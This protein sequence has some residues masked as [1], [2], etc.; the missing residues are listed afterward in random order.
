MRSIAWSSVVC[1]PDLGRRSA[2]RDTEREGRNHRA[3]GPGV[4]RRFRSGNALDRALAELVLVLRPPL[5]FV[6]AHDR[7]DRRAFRRQDADEG[8]D[9]AGAGDRGPAFAEV[10]PRSEEHTSELQSL[11]R[12]SYA[13]SCLKKK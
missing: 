8:A 1:S 10:F 11:M 7:R 9:H 13:A 4:V 12:I 2:A 3:A 6:V 5:G